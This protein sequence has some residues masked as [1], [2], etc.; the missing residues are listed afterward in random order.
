MAGASKPTPKDTVRALN[1]LTAEQFARVC[2]EIG[3]LE[4]T[5]PGDT[6]TAKASALVGKL[7]GEADFA[8]LVA[9]GACAGTAEAARRADVAVG[10]GVAVSVGRDVGEGV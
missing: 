7:R 5:L 1:R 6:Q 9:V 10:V 3:Y 2:S 8:V 4:V